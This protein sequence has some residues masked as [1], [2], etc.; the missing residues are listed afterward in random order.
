[1]GRGDRADF[2]GTRAR[3]SLDAAADKKRKTQEPIGR[4]AFPGKTQNPLRGAAG[5]NAGPFL[6]QGKLKT[7]D[8]T[9]KTGGVTLREAQGK[10]PPLRRQGGG[11]DYETVFYVAL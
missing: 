8:Y 2:A 5:R 4:S 3:E 10:K 6:R 11:V 7:G 9:E 1:M